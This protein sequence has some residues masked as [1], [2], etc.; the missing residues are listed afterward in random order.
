M[1]SSTEPHK[2]GAAGLSYD[3]HAL[4]SM[5]N[6]VLAGIGL[7]WALCLSY[8]A[9]M[10]SADV[11]PHRDIEGIFGPL[12]GRRF[13]ILGIGGGGDI[14]ST[15]PMCLQFE[16]LGAT[17]VPGG[18]TWKRRVHDPTHRPRAISEFKNV[19]TIA[20]CVGIGRDD[21]ET[22]DGVQHVEAF[23]SASLGGREVL[24]ID[25]SPGGAAVAAGLRDAARD[26]GLDGIIGVDVGG[27]ML[28][29]G[30]EATLE[31]PLCDQTLMFALAQSR[32][33]VVLASLGTDGEIHPQDFI[34]RFRAVHRNG[35]FR[36]AF[37]PQEEDLE[38]WE[39]VVR[40]AQTESSKH[41]LGVYRSLSCEQRRS[42]YEK[43]RFDPLHAV[44]SNLV[45]PQALPLRNGARTGHLSPLTA[46]YF[47]FDSG[48]VWGSG[49][50]S[51]MWQPD[52]SIERMHEVLT[53]RGIVTEFSEAP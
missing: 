52:L 37:V 43:L 6:V 25:P 48:I 7:S 22:V 30:F 20:P 45:E 40:G 36:G 12:A 16:R 34:A 21:M 3:S 28:C 14:T 23:I 33:P 24:V 32:S 15:V 46:F 4:R 8:S 5:R 53:A 31:S 13:A 11:F 9:R 1:S 2:S 17:V 26:L 39:R 10:S 50:F 29:D 35:G 47:V 41:A 38:T 44:E 51:L 18:L 42:I 19:R 27:D 49:Q